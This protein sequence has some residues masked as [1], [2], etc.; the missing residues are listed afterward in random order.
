[1]GMTLHLAT[2]M[3]M[4][5]SWCGL[6]SRHRERQD[7]G[8]LILYFVRPFFCRM[9]FFLETEMEIVHVALLPERGTK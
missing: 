7:S 4:T 1:M 9:F 8:K 2:I 3:T 6:I 5:L